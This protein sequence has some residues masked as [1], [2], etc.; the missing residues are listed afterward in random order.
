MKV[1]STTRYSERISIKAETQF[2]ANRRK[3]GANELTEISRS[4]G[5]SRVIQVRNVRDTHQM[6]IYSHD[7]FHVSKNSHNRRH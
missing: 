2:A 7:K 4:L 5:Q 6:L 3:N 1:F